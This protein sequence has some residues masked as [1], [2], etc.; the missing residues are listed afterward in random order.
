MFQK[1]WFIK[2]VIVISIPLIIY[3]FIRKK[4][5]FKKH[6]YILFFLMAAPAY[7]AGMLAYYFF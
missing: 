6:P 7:L 4:E 1:F 5:V 3:F 2:Y